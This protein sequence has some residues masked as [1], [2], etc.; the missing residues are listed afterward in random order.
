MLCS[1]FGVWWS[2]DCNWETLNLLFSQIADIAGAT[3]I[4][5]GVLE[6]FQGLPEVEVGIG[7]W[8][9][10]IGVAVSQT[11]PPQY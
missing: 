11:I 8:G 3:N 6:A 2:S 10:S 5:A 1:V 9:V 7:I 4:A